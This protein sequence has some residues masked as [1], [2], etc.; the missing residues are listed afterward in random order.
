M[1]VKMSKVHI[2]GLK[3][4]LLEAVNALQSFGRLHLTDLSESIQAGELPVSK[5]VL[6]VRSEQQRDQMLELQ[7]RGRA[8]SKGL[9]GKDFPVESCASGCTFEGMPI[10]EL[11]EAVRGYLD[12][13][14]PGAA[15]AV[16]HL[17][18][19]STELA[20]LS[21]YEPLMQKI[22]PVVE[23][24][25]AG[26]DVDSTALLIERRYKDAIGE[27]R[28]MLRT[29]SQGHTTLASHDIDKEMT[30]AIVI[31]DREFAPAVRAALAEEQL[32]RVKLPGDLETLP[33]DEALEKIQTRI[34]ALPGLIQEA[35]AVVAALADDQKVELCGS[36]TELSNRVGQLDAISSFGETEYAFIVAGYIPTRDLPELRKMVE[37]LWEDTVTVDE[38]AIDPHDFPEVPIKLENKGR[39]RAFQTVLGVWG[40]P[41]YGTIDPSTI[42]AL[43]FPF[44]WGMIVGDAGYG[45]TL[46]AICLALRWKFPSSNA[47][48]IAT[49]VLL[50]A[51]VMATVFGIFYFEFFGDLLHVY[52]PIIHIDPIPI[53]GNISFPFYRTYS[54]L[55]TTFLLMAIAVGA[56]Q[57]MAGL[58][59]GVVNNERLGHRKHSFEA[60]GILTVLVSALALAA[61]MALPNLT[62]GMSEQ[63]AAFLTYFIYVVIA[64]GLVA[65]VW[66]GGIAGAIETIGA[67][68]NIASY[69]RIMAVG[70]VGALLADAA[71]ALAF[72]TMP[73]AAGISIALILHVLNFVIICFSPSIHALRLNFLEFFGKFWKAGKVVYRPFVTTG[74]EGLS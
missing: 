65:T 5:M 51:G 9:L 11:I 30:A 48:H 3:A 18:D 36:I 57:V 26:R 21:H 10:A 56:I 62:A 67:V 27:L 53:I 29:V 33:F 23:N 70:L 41:M 39:F 28:D 14:E 69:I 13:V 35:A 19:L 61:V 74:K 47:V 63:G 50:P 44:L 8:L 15:E 54:S 4:H 16:R 17:A 22:A 71:N 7:Q 24:L 64:V 38:I 43:S 34:A 45:L 20:D 32:N 37:D 55:Q 58:V 31:T 52:L 68:S 40:Q 42:L 46:V 2:I 73:N 66:G 60:G 49:S 6:F 72:V 1:Q 25:T 12:T 59:L